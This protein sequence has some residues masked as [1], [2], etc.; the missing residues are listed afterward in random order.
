MRNILDIKSAFESQIAAKAVKIHQV[1]NCGA[2]RDMEKNGGHF[3]VQLQAEAASY[4]FL[5]KQMHGGTRGIIAPGDS[6]PCF[7]SVCGC[8]T[9]PYHVGDE[10]AR[11]YAQ[12]VG[13]VCRDSGIHN[14][15]FRKPNGY[16]GLLAH[17]DVRVHEIVSWR[18]SIRSQWE[19]DRKIPF[20]EAFKA[21]R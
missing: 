4:G 3:I 9:P 7:S 18:E 17:F 12:T 10:W 2:I 15:T 14:L 13:Q 16:A 11:F 21:V 1:P 20:R 6:G 5:V 8:C 19:K